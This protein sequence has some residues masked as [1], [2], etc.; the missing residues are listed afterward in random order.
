[1]SPA[2][3]Y[4]LPQSLPPPCNFE[5]NTTRLRHPS[6]CAASR[7]FS[8]KIMKIIKINARSFFS[9]ALFLFFSFL[10]RVIL[11]LIWVKKV[12]FECHS[13]VKMPKVPGATFSK[14]LIDI[15]TIETTN[16][17][18]LC[19]SLWRTALSQIVGFWMSLRWPVDLIDSDD[20]NL[21]CFTPGGG[22]ATQ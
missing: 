5:N 6:R 10:F 15:C 2:V 12:W 17:P 9:S 3:A 7:F 1:M 14:I 11:R 19:D 4:L 18:W 13:D 8:F 20:I 21:T 16:I 22:G